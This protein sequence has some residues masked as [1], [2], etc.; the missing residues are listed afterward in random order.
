M[1]YYAELNPFEVNGI[2]FTN[3]T[4]YYTYT[5]RKSQQLVSTQDLK[6]EKYRIQQNGHNRRY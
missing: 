3:E 6:D 5:N 1:S 4:N 2:Q